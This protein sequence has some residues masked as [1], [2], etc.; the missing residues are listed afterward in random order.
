MPSP[1]NHGAYVASALRAELD[2]V[3]SSSA[4]NRARTTYRAACALGNLVGSGVLDGEEVE[5]LLI[6]T[7]HATGLAEKEARQNVR[8]GLAHGARTPRG[9]VD[10][11]RGTAKVAGIP[12]R[13]PP[14]AASTTSRSATA[15]R[16]VQ[17]TWAAA[18]P[19]LDDPDATTWLTSRGLDPY[20]IELWDLA[21]VVV[22]GTTLPGWARAKGRSWW[23]TGHRL[24]V[25]LWGAHGDL[26]SL[27]A[28][29]IR[30]PGDLPKGLAPAGM[31]VSGRVM[32]CPLA[33]QLLQG[34]VPEWWTGHD[35]VI[36][37]GEPDFLTWAA[38]QGETSD[39]GPAVIGV[40]SG[41]WTTEIA[42]RIPDGSRVVLRTHQDA[43]G[44][45]Y[46]RRIHKT[47]HE[48]CEVYRP[49]GAVR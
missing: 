4:G 43:A 45:D 20:A 34:D 36:T 12:A 37:E 35:I 24:L 27:R 31:P 44:H 1:L 21:R 11:R 13:K 41:S 14:V 7:A 5:A 26:V 46:A 22:A 32:A 42:T 15:E 23:A 40:L 6:D 3:A 19:V 28:R 25:P 47:L 18:R 8:R 48:R 9:P 29:C 30:D 39:S 33:V 49:G 10:A 2:R 16:V 38:Q 17:A